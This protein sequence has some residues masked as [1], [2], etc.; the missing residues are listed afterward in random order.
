[1]LALEA[2]PAPKL[3]RLEFGI[4][5]VIGLFA[6]GMAVAAALAGGPEVWSHL[7]SLSLPLTVALLGLSLANYLLRGLR[8]HLY[9]RRVGAE[10]SLWQSL[11]Y[12]ISGFALT[13]TPGRV[14]EAFRLWMMQR[15]NGTPYERTL[16]VLV[17]DRLSD[18]GAVGLLMLFCLLTASPQ[19]WLLATALVATFVSF[20]L[21]L[22]PQI[23]L[24]MVG[25]TFRATGRWPRLFGR[26][27]GMVR[28]MTALFSPEVLL[29][30]LTLALA[31]WLAECYAFFLILQ[32]FGA[33]VPL[34]H[35][36]LIFTA[37]MLVG[38]VTL[39]P[40]GVGGTEATMLALLA[41]QGVPMELAI[42]AIAVIRVTTLWFAVALGCL[43]LP[44][45]L[46]RARQAL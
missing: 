16:P 21:A 20:L 18:L 2:L 3:R 8:W 27:R 38:A 43:A 30:T 12:Y 9:S 37:G 4:I 36:V 23:A 6:I 31:G 15:C 42:P 5:A 10:V 24:A 7:R 44:Q 11:F 13:T 34:H 46:R 25:M 22:R 19:P 14:G 45:A 1:M 29:L 39:I 28:R 33:E 26:L 35:A 41:A 32:A 40:G 17:A